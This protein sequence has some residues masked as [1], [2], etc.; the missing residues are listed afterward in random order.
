MEFIEKAKVRLDHWIHH[1][2]HHNEEYEMFADQLEEAGK[3]ECAGYIR[4]MMDLTSKSVE[5][6]RKALNAL[7]N[8]ERNR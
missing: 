5:C 6:L 2:D 7:D 8:G 3:S 4:E 1:S